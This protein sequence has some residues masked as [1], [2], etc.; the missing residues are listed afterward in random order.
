MSKKQTVA[1][2][3]IVSLSDLG[4]KH[5]QLD[6][7]LGSYAEYALKVFG[8][9]FPTMKRNDPDYADKVGELAS[10]YLSYWATLP[11]NTPTVYIIVEGGQRAT[12]VPETPANKDTKGDRVEVTAHTV[13][14]HS[15]QAFG[16]YKNA[17]ASAD[18]MPKSWQPG[19]HAIAEKIRKGFSTYL[20]KKFSDLQAKA[21]ELQNPEG[22]PR[23]RGATLDQLPKIRKTQDS[24]LKSCK[25]AKGRGDVTAYP[26]RME[27]G[28]TIFNEVYGSAVPV[29]TIRAAWSK[30]L[31]DLK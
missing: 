10:G 2:G 19:Y 8:S 22:T 13:M 16:K 12:W 7:T 18:V 25:V 26:D 31:K 23:S 4:F 6:A 27:L 17:D 29:E 11:R 30:M 20:S 15:Q 5:G 28:F 9:S 24:M 3:N 21:R 14:A 1:E